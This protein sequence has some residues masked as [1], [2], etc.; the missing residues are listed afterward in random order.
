MTAL[1]QSGEII[2]S[3]GERILGRVTAE[4][5][6]DPYSREVLVVRNTLVDE[7]TAER[8]ES[9]GLEH[10]VMRSVLT[11]ELKSGICAMCYGRNL[12]SGSLAE[13]GEAVGVI[14]A[15]SIGEPGTQ[16]TM[17]TFHIG[18]AAS[19]QVDQSTLQAKN[20]G[21]VRYQNL[22]T[23]NNR[24]GAMVVMNRNGVLV[25]QDEEEREKERYPIEYGARLR[26]RMVKRSNAVRTWSSGILTLV[27]F[28]QR[29]PVASPMA[30]LWKALPFRKN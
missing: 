18:G 14:A 6:L 13:I 30:I 21:V 2:E 12:A 5:V 22:R 26:V 1:V 10:V 9:A 17:R 4:D 11:C 20:N 27:P 23:V 19:L 28:F 24:E 16:L 3:L 29:F 15:Q 7:E 8:L 25:I